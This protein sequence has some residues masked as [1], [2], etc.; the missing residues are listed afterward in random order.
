MPCFQYRRARLDIGSNTKCRRH[1]RRLQTLSPTAPYRAIYGADTCRKNRPQQQPHQPF[2]PDLSGHQFRVPPNPSLQ[3]QQ[4][5]HQEG[6]RNHAFAERNI[7]RPPAYRR[8][9]ACRHRLFL[10]PP[11]YRTRRSAQWP[12]PLSSRH[13]PE[14]ARHPHLFAV[15]RRN[16]APTCGSSNRHLR[17]AACLLQ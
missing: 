8:P 15:Q 17:K 16:I 5:K 14:V 6:R 12:V 7:Y 9:P 13:L 3:T 11:K 10:H 2:Q 4:V 1:L